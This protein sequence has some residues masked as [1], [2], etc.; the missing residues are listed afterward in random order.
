MRVFQRVKDI[1][2]ANISEFQLH[3][4]ENHVCNEYCEIYQEILEDIKEQNTFHLAASC[5]MLQLA[6]TSN[7]QE[8]IEETIINMHVSGLVLG[9]QLARAIDMEKSF[10]EVENE[11]A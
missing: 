7:I 4:V 6:A 3:G 11:K 5:I 2:A 9:M 10:A 1:I 8:C